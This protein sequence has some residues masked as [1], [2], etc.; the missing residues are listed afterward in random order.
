MLRALVDLQS[1]KQKHACYFK[2]DSVII[3]ASLKLATKLLTLIKPLHNDS[4]M[5]NNALL[6]TLLN[7]RLCRNLFTKHAFLRYPP[8]PEPRS[9]NL[10]SWPKLQ[11]KLYLHTLHCPV[12][13]SHP[14]HPPME[15][16]VSQGAR[17][18]YATQRIATDPLSGLVLRIVYQ[19]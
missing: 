11:P 10:P 14:R 17:N 2:K 16:P 15:L 4:T 5:W 12:S 1:R 3:L 13:L 18:G 6:N 7:Q 9:N 19:P 8:S